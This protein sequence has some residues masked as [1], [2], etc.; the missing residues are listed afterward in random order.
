MMMAM[1]GEKSI[2]IPPGST[3]R[4]GRRIGSVTSKRKRES[5]FEYCGSNHDN[6][7]LPMIAKVSTVKSVLRKKLNVS[8]TVNLPCWLYDPN[9]III[10]M[11]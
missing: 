10:P 1:K 4:I 11:F 3:L 7:A 5:G 2:I 9:S 8:A 6:K